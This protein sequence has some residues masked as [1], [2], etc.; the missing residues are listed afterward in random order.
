MY[1]VEKAWK[2]GGECVPLFEFL[3]QCIIAIMAFSL[4]ITW[5]MIISGA[6]EVVR[7]NKALLRC[8]V[9]VKLPPFWCL[10]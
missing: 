6:M 10:C 9:R 3:C 8:F 2:K 7:Q 5:S 1:F 4:V